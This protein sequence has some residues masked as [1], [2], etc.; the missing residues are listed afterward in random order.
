MSVTLAARQ[1]L[2]ETRARCVAP[3]CPAQSQ[4]PARSSGRTLEVPVA[5]AVG[6]APEPRR[7]VLAARQQPLPVGAQAQ[8]VD[9]SLVIRADLHGRAAVPHPG[10]DH[11]RFEAPRPRSGPAAVPRRPT[12]AITSAPNHQ[13]A[14]AQR[15]KG[16]RGER[17]QSFHLPAAASLPQA[18]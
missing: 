5:L 7:A 3:A 17:V 18:G 1:G 8:P 2:K 10:A 11:G 13:Q 14:P 16:E 9:A 15:H 6:R 4:R 12:S